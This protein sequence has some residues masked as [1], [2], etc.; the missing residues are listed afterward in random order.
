MNLFNYLRGIRAFTEGRAASEAGKAYKKYLEVMKSSHKEPLDPFFFMMT[1]PGA[2]SF[3]FSVNDI[4]NVK[5]KDLAI[6]TGWKN[7]PHGWLVTVRDAKMEY[8]ICPEDLAMAEFPEGL[9][10]IIRANMAAEQC[11]SG[12]RDRVH[13]KVD[14]AFD[15][16]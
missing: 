4:V 12:L 6:V 16:K 3:V 14:E 1:V 7:T 13:E 8:D 10:D 15:G 2:G 9:V 5:S 11:A